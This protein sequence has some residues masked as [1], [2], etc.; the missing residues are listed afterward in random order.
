LNILHDCPNNKQFFRNYG[1]SI[2]ESHLHLLHGKSSRL[3]CPGPKHNSG[4]I[5]DRQ[6]IGHYSVWLDL[7]FSCISWYSGKL[8]RDMC[9]LPNS[10]GRLLLVSYVEYSTIRCTHELDHRVAHFSW[11]LD[12]NFE[13]QLLRCSVDSFHYYTMGRLFCG[14]SVANRSYVLGSHGRRICSQC[15]WCQ[16]SRLDQQT[17][18]ILDVCISNNHHYNSFG[19]VG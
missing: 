7:C 1:S 2:Y 13:H 6:P 14:K 10:W 16:V 3:T 9:C 8:S 4:H 15:I 19:Y 12:R 18:H 11:E 5:L 17:L